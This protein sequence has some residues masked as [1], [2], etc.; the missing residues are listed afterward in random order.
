MSHLVVR[1]R[2]LWQVVLARVVAVVLVL[3]LAWALYEFGRYQGG[4]LAQESR[5]LEQLLTDRA[6]KLER[7]NQRLREQQAI[8]ARS[9]QIDQEA[10]K[11][12][13]ATV[14]GLQ[15]ELAELKR[16]LDFYR[17]I[18]SPGDASHSLEIQRF[19]LQAESAREHRYTL[20][21]T[22][23]LNNNNWASGEV[24]FYLEGLEGDEEVTY[25][26]AQLSE[27][28]GSLAF[29]YRYFQFFEGDFE[30]PEG[31]EPKSVRLEVKPRGRTHSAFSQSFDWVV[32][33]S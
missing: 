21:L 8:L 23:V 15:G 13:E 2:P 1:A 7:E 16:E 27:H 33:E 22:Q 11:Q 24:E 20:V 5:Q 28:E 29:R 25:T 17:G 32:G 19:E 30:L 14:N 12:L 18:V 10:Y 31:F 9:S 26:L 4:Y 6:S 3:L